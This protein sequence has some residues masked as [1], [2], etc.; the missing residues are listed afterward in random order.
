MAITNLL[1]AITAKLLTSNGT[2]GG[3]VTIADTSIFQ[4]QQVVK[5]AG[6]AKPTITVQIQRINSATQMIVGPINSAPPT[7]TNI[8]TY[9]VAA[10]SNISADEQ[11]KRVRGGDSV[12]ISQFQPG[13]AVAQR[14]LI[15][16]PLG[17]PI[18]ST[19]PLPTSTTISGQPIHTIVDS[20]SVTVVQPTGTNLHAVIDSGAISLPV[21]A[22]TSA[23]QTT[24]NSSLSSID[25]KLN[26][27]GQKVSGASVPVV[28]ASDQTAVHTIVD[29]GVITL[30]VGASTAANQV[31]ANASL[32]SIDGKLNSLGQKTSAA[33]VPVVLAS[34]QS[35]IGVKLQD[36]SGNGIT[37]EVYDSF[38]KL[39]VTLGKGSQ[40]EG[41]TRIRVA[42]PETT[43]GL[44]FSQTSH[45]LY[46]STATVGAGASTFSSTQ[47]VLN[48]TTTTASGDSVIMQSRK[49]APY[50]PGVS[51]SIFIS[52]V[53]G[54]AKTNLRKR[55]GYFDA[56]NGFFFEQTGTDLAIVT[57][58]SSSGAPVDTRVVQASWNLDKLNGT[59]TSGVT[60]DLTK[61]NGFCFD[62]IWS[63]GLV[64]AG[65]LFNDGVI[66][67]H[68]I[69]N[70]NTLALPYMATP[71][72][73]LRFEMVNT[74]V[75]ASGSTMSMIG[76]AILKDSTDP[77]E[78]PYTFGAT[79]GRTSISAA[80]TEI[81]LIS[82]RPKTT[83]NS[84]AN[85]VS[86]VPDALT[87]VSSSQAVIVRVY[88]N[89]TLTG[90][91][92]GSAG[93]NS[94]TEFDITATAITG[95]T[96]IF[97]TYVESGAGTGQVDLLVIEGVANLGL[98]L[99][100]TPDQLNISVQSVAGGT[101]T[102]GGITWHEYQ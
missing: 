4:E 87:V 11:Q 71:Q 68:T 36:S 3:V 12:I 63:S 43:L 78:P 18:S 92:F 2:S 64:R 60:L 5:I 20:G 32:S 72:L 47:Q 31:I 41:Y 56:N 75:V 13:P 38:R 55:W 15:V 73:P 98:D 88:L 84:V 89:A 57:R 23:L 21:G 14:N 26:S 7:V 25:G 22:S 94:A 80:A 81:P 69:S 48:F 61:N 58:T 83:F 65:I 9:T 10:A 66:L 70:A 76:S 102:F 90:A 51:H 91:V 30:P 99:T 44:Y 96:P 93:T 1:Q 16:D 19:N 77:L 59:G 34:D 52:G 29:S 101:N 24:G 97:E 35:A 6:T 79:R 8:S 67:A 100:G 53:M 46:F 85:N 49:R 37:S 17:V 27:L 74:G 95:G 28:I 39:D 82:I 54:V 86:I 33:S 45:P 62:F 50:L 40:V 42:P